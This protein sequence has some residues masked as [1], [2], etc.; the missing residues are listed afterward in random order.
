MRIPARRVRASGTHRLIPSRYP[1][2][3]LFDAVADPRDLALV[4]ELEG[5]TNDRLSAELGVLSLIPRDEWV[6]GRAMASVIMAAY[7]HPSPNGG[8]FNDGARGAWYAAFSIE[9]AH[10]EAI[11]RRTQ[12]LLES[13]VLETRVEMREYRADFDARFHDIRARNNAY[14]HLYDPA[15]HTA[16]Q[17]LAREL[18]TDGSNGIVYRSVRDDGSTCLACFRPR[19]VLNVRQGAHFEYVW[20]GFPKPRIRRLR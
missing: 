11:H 8:R 16:S 19:L 2:V 20:E 12:E 3:G 6:V 13:G 9:T 15:S 17:E 1:P 14:E 4:I 10:A 7:C 18:L 5:W